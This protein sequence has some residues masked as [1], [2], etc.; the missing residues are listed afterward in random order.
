MGV[1]I[2]PRIGIEGEAEYRKSIN[3][4]ITQAKTF[5]AEM[6]EL[7]SS[8]DENT[9]AM[10]KNRKKSDL[11]NRQ[12]KTQEELV[13]SLEG[14]LERATEAWG[15][16]DA[17]T[18]KW[19]QA[20]SN[21]KTDLHRLNKELENTPT[22]LQSVGQEMQNVGKKMQSIG[23]NMTK[24]V[25]API[26][27]AAAASVAAWKEVDDGADTVATKT[28]ATGEALVGLQTSMKNIATTIPTTFEKAGEAVGE[29]NTRFHLTG[30]ELEALSTRFIKFAD[31]NDTDVTN[32][33]DKAQKILSAYGLQVEDTGTLLDAMTKTS[34]DT[35][36]SVDKLA[37]SM[38]KNA[39]SLQEMGMNAY[40]AS[41][42][43]GQLEVS[44]VDVNTA[45]TGMQKAMVNAA[46]EGKTLPEA[47][48]G[49]QQTLNSSTSEQDKLNAAIDLFGAKTGP[50]IYAA[51]KSGSLSFEALSQDASY[52]MGTVETTFDNVVDPID[53][54]QTSLNKVKVAGEK[55]GGVLLENAAPA[56][57]TLA[58]KVETAGNWFA[59][60]SEEQQK[61]VAYA[62]IFAGGV[63]PIIKAVGGI[64]EG[65]GESIEKFDKLK[66][67]SK[68]IGLLTDPVTGI[69]A[70]LTVTL[71]AVL[72]AREAAL[73]SNETLQTVL[74]TTG[75][76][77][78]QLESATQSLS[79]TLTE[80]EKNISEI[81]GKSDVAKDLVKELAALEKQSNKTKTEQ[82]RMKTIVSELNTMY[83]DLNLSIDEMT[84]SLSKSTEE[85]QNY[86][87]NAR[88]MA[89]L[90]AYIAGAKQGYAD[91]AA[92]QIALKNAQEA[93]AESTA[94]LTKLRKEYADATEAAG[95]TLD[96]TGTPIQNYTGKMQEAGAAV[97]EA[98]VAH[99]KLVEATKAAQKKYD[100]A[101]E[102]ISGYEEAAEEL[103][104]KLDGAGE[105]TDTATE[106]TGTFADMLKKAGQ[107]ADDASETIKT[108]FEEMG[109]S[110][111]NAV[112]EQ[113]KAWLD[114]YKSTKDSV[115]NQSKLF[116]ELK[117]SYEKTARDIANTLEENNKAKQ[118][119][120]ANM[121][122]L[123]KE[124]EE[125][126]DP[127]M[128]QFVQEIA[129][130][131]L[132]AAGEVDALVKSLEGDG[133]DFAA[134]FE[135]YKQSCTLDDT[136][137]AQTA[138]F[139]SGMN[140]INI[141]A[142]Q[143][144]G[145]GGTVGQSM[146]GLVGNMALAMLGVNREAT[147]KTGQTVGGM[148]SKFAGAN[149][150]SEVKKIGVPGLLI[151][152]ALGI[153]SG[154]L[155][156]TA[157][158]KSINTPSNVISSAESSVNKQFGVKATLTG[159]TGV[160]DAAA[161]ARAQIEHKVQNIKAS[162][163]Y[164]GVNVQREY[165]EGG[166][167]TE[168]QVALVGEAGPEAII[169]LSTTMRSRAL[170]LY[171]QVGEALGV[172]TAAAD[173]PVNTVN[174]PKHRNAASSS[175][176]FSQTTLDNLF[177]TIAA[178]A[179]AGS[180]AGM[181]EANLR[182]YIGDREVGRI[183]RNQGVAFA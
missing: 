116:S 178:A 108:G 132:G 39:G 171:E 158:T 91:L 37:D 83:P 67:S 74:S 46:K 94:N 20:V 57:E 56:I 84:G 133:V 90:D 66:E 161:K 29:V 144:F 115:K 12:I 55:I 101:Q 60:L 134:V 165:A 81:N 99:D 25:T 8:F 45:M 47:L 78:E 85:I 119:Y 136:I 105:Q 152:T 63:G 50:A 80:T 72:E 38:I 174:V 181:E 16:N 156:P 110:A 1:S 151:S 137:A 36:L 71:A 166:L 138:T 162:V 96:A 32:S 160:T 43:L 150:Q 22:K 109:L 107:V 100:E 141:L 124:V 40:D 170:D 164:A 98:V 30:E 155:K 88:D 14:Q 93:E 27:A 95:T 173:R 159:I 169:P 31:I 114:S 87:E 92:A 17:R 2:G 9:S 142:G 49:F 65:V 3:G 23:D 52:Y 19:K 118:R 24:Y 126:N 35:G 179:Q 153:M 175:A 145:N 182:V 28:G 120:S 183:L 86:I 42:F 61:I 97:D 135:A 53:T 34:Q 89:L 148:E 172:D 111:K 62:G 7:E 82:A 76:A 79:D 5:S 154:G 64:T 103:Q 33:V 121:A 147:T 143:T 10:E 112:N 77:Q 54:F 177:E 176:V 129:E 123:F 4:L 122:V 13:S 163:S 59:S 11:L 15:E 41:A 18:Q 44:G 149:L 73:E 69:T 102:S 180:R 157:T 140:L 106:K 127:Y 21:A 117:V 128:R 168:A 146:M 26:A 58:E 131:G 113:A 104:T 70:G 167:V 130:M 68:I 75:E 51:C 125:S 139:Q 48:Q 6:K